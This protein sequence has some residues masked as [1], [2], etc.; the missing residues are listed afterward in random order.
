MAPG[1]TEELVNINYTFK[2]VE[3]KNL[4]T[5]KEDVHQKVAP[6]LTNTPT[7]ATNQV[8][9]NQTVTN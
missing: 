4:E 5:C 3:F 9:I 7:R 8:H 2:S 6:R 1:C